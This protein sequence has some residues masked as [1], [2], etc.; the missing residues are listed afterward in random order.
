MAFQDVS[1]I[2]RPDGYDV[3]GIDRRQQFE[4]VHRADLHT[5]L[6]VAKHVAGHFVNRAG[7]FERAEGWT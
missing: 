5:D 2:V 7:F 3:A 6:V 4:V 1:Q